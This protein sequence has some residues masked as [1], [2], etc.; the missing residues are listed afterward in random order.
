MFWLEAEITVPA[1]SSVKLDAE[2]DKEPSLDFV[3][4]AENRG[5]SGYDLVTGLGSNLP[6]TGQTARLEDRGQAE[7]DHFLFLPPHF[8]PFILKNGFRQRIIVSAN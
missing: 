2:F 3:C 7:A 6:F 4:G 5:I 8:P 1:G